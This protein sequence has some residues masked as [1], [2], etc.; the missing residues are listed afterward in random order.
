MSKC[1]GK[2]VLLVSVQNDVSDH[3]VALVD[4]APDAGSAQ[5]FDHFS[6]NLFPSARTCHPTKIARF[7]TT[8]LNGIARA[9]FRAP[10]LVPSPQQ[11]QHLL[12]TDLIVARSVADA[13]SVQTS[14]G[15]EPP[16]PA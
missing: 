11:K 3:E 9:S 14:D 8:L 4:I 16:A 12:S 15:H 13:H 7:A 10:V 2:P 5:A 1:N 6:Q